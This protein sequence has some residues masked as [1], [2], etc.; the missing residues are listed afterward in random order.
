M[1]L[2]IDGTELRHHCSN[3]WVYC[4]SGIEVSQLILL[5]EVSVLSR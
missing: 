1:A 4:I 5:S 2:M 3:I